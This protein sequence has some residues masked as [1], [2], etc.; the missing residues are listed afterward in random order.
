ME[1]Q[2]ACLAFKHPG[3]GGGN[4]SLQPHTLL[5]VSPAPVCRRW[6]PQWRWSRANLWFQPLLLEKKA[7]S[8]GSVTSL[9]S[10]SKTA[11]YDRHH[12]WAASLPTRQLVLSLEVKLWTTWRQLSPD[13]PVSADCSFKWP[14]LH[15]ML[16]FPFCPR[17]KLWPCSAAHQFFDHE[18]MSKD[19]HVL[20]W[21]VSSADVL[22]LNIFWAFLK[23]VE[24][25]DKIEDVGPIWQEMSGLF[26]GSPEEVFETE[27]QV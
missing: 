10:I 1:D 5:K 2:K 19:E 27:A 13:G 9:C 7:S 17:T 11:N 20:G 22:P 8:A 25:W 26:R 6:R 4:L 16:Q 15:L 24:I 12:S 18:I 23:R 14:S 21:K 3:G